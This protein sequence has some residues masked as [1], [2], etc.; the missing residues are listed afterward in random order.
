[1]L[2]IWLSRSSCFIF[3]NTSSTSQRVR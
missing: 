3:L 1:L 2:R